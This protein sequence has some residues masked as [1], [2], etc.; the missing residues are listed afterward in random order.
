MT[1][2]ALGISRLDTASTATVTRLTDPQRLDALRHCGL[3]H[4]TANPVL[5]GLARITTHVLSVPIA[6]VA[7]V[8]DRRQHLP[9]MAGV[10]DWGGEARGT[11]LSHAFAQLVVVRDQTVVIP[12]LASDGTAQEHPG[13]AALRARAFIG[14]PLRLEGGA[15][16]GAL[17]AVHTVP[18]NW[19]AEHVALLEDLAAAAVSE[20]ERLLIAQAFA[21]ADARWRDEVDHDG[22]TGLLNR[23]GFLD[24]ARHH[25]ALAQR[26]AAPFS[27][28]VLD[29]DQFT[30]INDVFGHAAGDR[31]LAE[32]ASLLRSV[33]R[34]TD[35]VARFDDDGF[36]VL[37]CNTNHEEAIRFRERVEEGLSALNASPGREYQLHASLG[38][39]S[40]TLEA[41]HTLATLLRVAEESMHIEKGHRAGRHP[42]AVDRLSPGGLPD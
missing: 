31:A 17:C 33:G 3:L 38:I 26:T 42:S 19:G 20:I 15:V 34:E 23:R 41:P 39:A 28:A 14:A 37:L 29:I 4:G 24:Q 7:L 16:V 9:G 32:M 2:P 1:L 6:C 12:D 22:Q 35:L 11:P 25:L 8:D 5:D 30:A 36:A 18:M 21:Q 13:F 27:I 40:W 10:A